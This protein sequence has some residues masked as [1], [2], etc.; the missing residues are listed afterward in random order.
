MVVSAWFDTGHMLVAQIAK[1]QVP[2][3]HVATVDQILSSWSS[4]FPGMSDFVNSAVWPDHIKC[5]N[6]EAPLCTG[7]PAVALRACLV[8][9]VRSRF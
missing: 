9:C 7:M 8:V 1:T 5:S 6:T 3:R 2:Q 4:D